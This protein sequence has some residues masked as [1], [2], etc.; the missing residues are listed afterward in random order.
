[1][2]HILPKITAAALSIV[3]FIGTANAD[4]S[5]ESK[6]GQQMVARAIQQ[7]ANQPSVEAE[8]RQRVELFGRF[9]VGSG[10]YRQ[11]TIGDQRMFRLEM[12]L[13]VA[14]RLTSLLQVSNGSTLWIRHGIGDTKNLAY[15]NLG[16]VREALRDAPP[17]VGVLSTKQLAAGGLHQL[18]RGLEDCFDFREPTASQIGN[19]PV[20]HL[21]GH[22]KAA[23]LAQLL[24][25]EQ[26]A[27]V[28]A[29]PSEVTGLPAQLP[30]VVSLFL[31]RDQEIPLFPYQIEYGR[32]EAASKTP[33][34]QDNPAR[35]RAIAILQ[36]FEVR[37]YRNMDPRDFTFTPVDEQVD[38]RT[39][40]WIADLGRGM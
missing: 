33:P 35:Y 22:W 34:K 36:L 11:L 10:N 12:K 4:R 23:K 24:S 2:N 37:R 15:V 20:W 32:F 17:T 5:I 39:E 40:E 38:D 28:A 19:L 16:K 25:P 26:A 9:L 14:D 7:I 13:Q 1:M 8:L 18:L 31:G 6:P 30:S 29:N 3:C 21:K 27:L